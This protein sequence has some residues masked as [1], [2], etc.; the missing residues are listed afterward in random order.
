[1]LLRRAP[2]R[3]GHGDLIEVAGRPV[4]LK[5]NPRARRVSLRVDAVRREVVATAP[6]PRR[7]ADA[8]AF[9]ARRADWIAERFA[10]LPSG[11]TLTPGAMIEVL[12]APCRLERAA[13]R[14][15]ARLID[16]AGDEP[17]RLIAYGEGV[18]YGRAVER[19]LRT[20][21]LERLTARTQAYS[22]RLGHPAPEVKIMGARSRWGSCRQA[23]AGAP[24]RVR[25]NWRLVLTPAE[26]LDYVAAHECAHL[27]EANHGPGF[28]S[29]VERLYGDPRSARAWLRREGARLHAV[30]GAER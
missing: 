23:H 12:G 5:V 17:A 30:A 15:P 1:M 28:W 9:A 26:I 11:V 18:S 25:Y 29:L 13:M 4:R 21:A 27:T 10:A 19:A 8:A 3:H 24:A 2:P 6:S 20:A 14:I 22:A 7:L 16:A